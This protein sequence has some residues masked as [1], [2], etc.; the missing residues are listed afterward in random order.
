MQ[1]GPEQVIVIVM[2][3]GRARVPSFEEVKDEMTQ[4]ATLDGLERARKQWLQELR[5]KVYIDVRL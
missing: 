4:R 5:R 1:I 3:M 2:P